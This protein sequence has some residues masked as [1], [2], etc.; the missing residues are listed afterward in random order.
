MT[1]IN[2]TRK[3]GYAPMNGSLSRLLN[4]NIVTFLLLWKEWRVFRFGFDIALWKKIMV[5]TSPMIIVGLGGM[6]NETIDRI[7]LRKLLPV[8]EEAAKEDYGWTRSASK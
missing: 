1:T 4:P 5:Y 3:H 6:V 2:A 8:S 7:M